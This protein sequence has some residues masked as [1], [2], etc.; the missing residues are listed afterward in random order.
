M[1]EILVLEPDL[2]FLSKIREPV[3]ALGWTCTALRTAGAV[4]ARVAESPPPAALVVR[5]GIP[6]VAWE[7]AIQAAKTAGVPVLAYGAHVDAAG[8]A[9]ARQAGATRVVINSRL[10][11][12]VAGQI[13]QTIARQAADLTTEE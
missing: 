7:A 10:A 11:A 4:A 13:Q 5:F 12:D 8:Q 6:G 2:F 1:I 3:Q 9:A